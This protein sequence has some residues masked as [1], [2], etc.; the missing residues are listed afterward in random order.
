[1][2]DYLPQ[3]VLIK[4]LARLPPVSLIKFRCVSKSWSLL[5]SSPFFISMETEQAILSQPIDTR[6]EQIIVRRYS[7]AQNSKVYTVH[8]DNEEFPDDK[9]IKIEYLFRDSTRF[10]YRIV[11]SCNGVLCLSDVLFGQADS[12]LLWNP[13]IKRKVT[14]SVLDTMEPYMFVLEFE[15]DVE[16][17]DYKLVR[18]AY[19][20]G[21]YGYLVPPKVEVNALS[22]GNWREFSG[23]VPANCVVEY[24]WSERRSRYNL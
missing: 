11:C 24:F 23:E 19:V 10:Y 1:M 8:I 5:I 16:N 9:S 13:M 2:S 12:T 3:E 14:L 20:R 15:F 4:I 17:N 7:K 22:I 21:D 18:M 6:T